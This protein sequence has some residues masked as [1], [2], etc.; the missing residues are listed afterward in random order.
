LDR[1]PRKESKKFGYGRDRNLDWTST[2]PRP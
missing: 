2:R 1:Q